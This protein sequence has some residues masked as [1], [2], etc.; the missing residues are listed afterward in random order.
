M[1]DLRLELRLPLLTVSTDK[2]SVKFPRLG[3]GRIGPL[4]IVSRASGLALDTG[5]HADPETNVI[6]YR[7][8]GKRQQLW[9][10]RPGGTKGVVEIISADNGLTLDS[11]RATGDVHPL[12]R[13]AESASEPWQRWALARTPDGVGQFIRSVHSR[14]CLA[15]SE[16]SEDHWEPWF[17]PEK[18]QVNIQWLLVQP[19]GLR[20]R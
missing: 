12:M 19:F 11:T 9:Y 8:H 3:A 14:R 16:S 7:L 18:G 5:L 15:L 1:V 17:E 10:L 4:M 13:V 20:A 2:L 6:G